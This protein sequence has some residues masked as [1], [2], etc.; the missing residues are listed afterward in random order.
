MKQ[1]IKSIIITATVIFAL[2]LTGCKKYE[3]EP[4]EQDGCDLGFEPNTSIEDFINMYSGNGEPFLIDTNIIIKGTVIA[5]DKSGN[6]Y[7]SFVIQDST[8]TGE[9]TGLLIS[10][11][12]YE[13]H[14]KYHAGDMLYIKCE[15]L[16]LGFYG[17]VIQLG[18]LYEGEIGRIEEPLVD[19]HIFNACGGKPIKPK[20]VQISQLNAVPV[21]T[22]IE[23]EDVQFK[24]G[25]LDETY[26]DAVNK[27]TT[28]QVLVNCNNDN[29]IVRTS[30]YAKFA[31]DTIPKGKGSLIAVKGMYNSDVQLIIKDINDVKLSGVRCGAI[32]E[33][34]FDDFDFESPGS[35][36]I[37]NFV[38]GCWMTYIAEGT[39]NWVL[40]SY[41][42][43][44]YYA[45]ISNYDGTSNSASEAW[46]ISPAMNMALLNNP[47]LNFISAF[48][49]DGDD[50]TVKISTDYTGSE[51]PAEATWQ[52]LSVTLPSSGGYSWTNSGDVDLSDFIE[53][54]SVYI[55]FVYTGSDSS[56][57]HWE[58]DNISISEN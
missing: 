31:A 7:K 17:G 5:N 36:S 55:A 10:V 30:G 22:L 3:F 19:L 40:A 16:Y 28:D 1:I 12:E 29:V 53:S 39:S 26:A 27:V 34:D 24:L 8:E 32:Y 56:G 50:I 9:Q 57:K 25:E 44:N 45:E 20:L 35:S 21:N 43:D 6:Y 11:N 46:L 48:N 41:D 37:D 52:N 47:V 58:V 4:P 2:T 49:Y 15:G 23:L 18:A 13:T 14:N 51:S 38:S 33:K 54:S 42:G